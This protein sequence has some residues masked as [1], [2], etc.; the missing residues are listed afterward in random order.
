MLPKSIIKCHVSLLEYNLLTLH[1][2]QAGQLRSLWSQFP[3]F[4]GLPVVTKLHLDR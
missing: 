4:D 1:L 2:I 3:C